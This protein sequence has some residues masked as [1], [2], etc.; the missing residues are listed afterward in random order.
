MSGPW[1]IGVHSFISSFG[2]GS[3]LTEPPQV[4]VLDPASQWIV[5][6]LSGSPA[7]GIAVVAIAWVGMMMLWGRIDVR[8]GAMVI[9][10]CFVLFGAPSIAEGLMG[11][12]QTDRGD[13]SALAGVPIRPS[14]PARPKN[15]ANAFDPYA[16]A[17]VQR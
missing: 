6:T 15:P 16:G 11:S 12:A 1:G 2:A 10:G 3:S 7:T 5:T 13:V 14:L 17:A 4:S 8:R 9:V